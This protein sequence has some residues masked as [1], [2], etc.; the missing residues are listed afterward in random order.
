[1]KS[2]N[3]CKFPAARLAVNTLDIHCF[4]R[5]AEAAVMKKERRLTENRL[6]LLTEGEGVLTVDG[7][8]W[9]LRAG[10]LLFAFPGETVSFLGEGAVYMYIDFSGARADEL[11]RRFDVTPLSR[12]Q[13]GQDGLIPLWQ[14][15][16][17]RSTEAT[18]DLAAESLLL[19][20][21]SRLTRGE[22][23]GGGLVGEV[24]RITEES[25]SDPTLGIV[26][27]AKQLSY[28]PK[29]LSHLFKSKTGVGFSEYLRSVRLK[30]AVML[31]DHGI[32]SVKNVALLSGF[33]DPLYFSGVF[34]KSIGLS[35]KEYLA[36]KKG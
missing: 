23:Q 24:V 32:D 22:A 6:L 4:V 20:S 10:T 34:K 9:S 13:E 18:T 2:K 21:F 36:G 31:F 3:I 19:L 7:T 14:E 30:Y 27:I 8:E 15:S 26:S 5:E 1:M 35:P 33:S 28:H 16:L 29:Y 17:F 25:F 11:L 12:L